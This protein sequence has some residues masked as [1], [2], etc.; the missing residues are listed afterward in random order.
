M[1]KAQC[2]RK[3]TLSGN[4]TESDIDS[5][6][7]TDGGRS[8]PKCKKLSRMEEVETRRNE[9]VEELHDKHGSTY[10]MV[11]YRLWAEM[12]IAKTHDS[13]DQVPSA[14]MFGGK[15][16]RG[17][18]ESSGELTHA[19]AEMAQSICNALSPKTPIRSPA[20]AYPSP[21]KIVELR[22]KYMQQLS[23]LVKLRE[24]GALSEEEYEEQRSVVVSSM[25]K[26][27]N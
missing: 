6:T 21:T 15:R 10:S 17:R 23:D 4:N 7:G 19:L 8:K 14:P 3:R 5:D 26:L 1:G 12:I 11:Q 16:P 22:S 9:L 18:S 24:I 25:R 27:N 13:T 2:K 20:N